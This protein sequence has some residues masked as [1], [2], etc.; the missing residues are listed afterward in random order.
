M[1]SYK[2]VFWYAW[3]NVNGI[4]TIFT[5]ISVFLPISSTIRTN[6]HQHHHLHHQSSPSNAFESVLCPV[7][8]YAAGVISIECRYPLLSFFSTPLLAC[9]SPLVKCVFIPLETDFFCF[10][11]SLCSSWFAYNWKEK[12]WFRIIIISVFREKIGNVEKRESELLEFSNREWS[13]TFGDNYNCIPGDN[14]HFKYLSSDF[15]SWIWWTST[16][17]SF[18][19]CYSYCRSSQISST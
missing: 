9:F 17:C 13:L 15:T 14:L 7:P 5:T 6:R 11:V 16:G 1:D 2:F 3:S 19:R 8:E 4:F 18:M 12:N 10:V